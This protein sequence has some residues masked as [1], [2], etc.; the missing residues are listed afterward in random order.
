ML[1]IRIALVALA[2]LPL[3]VAGFAQ[4]TQQAPPPAE[5][6]EAEAKQLALK[7]VPGKTV[8]ESELEP[9]G[10][11]WIF[12]VLDAKGRECV[13]VVSQTT[14]SV[15]KVIAPR[16]T[17]QQALAIALRKVPGKR[18]SYGSDF[19][20][21]DPKRADHTFYIETPKKDKPLKIVT[22]SD[23]TGKVVGVSD[24]GDAG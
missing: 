22:V 8:D 14:R 12:H 5:L 13:V 11:V 3:S 19:S 15:S 1:M 9:V 2:L 23:K 6:S 10:H 4:E 17:V 21:F 20:T 24:K 18:G 7:R 16:L